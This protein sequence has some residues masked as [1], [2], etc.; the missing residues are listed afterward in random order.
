MVCMTPPEGGRPQEPRWTPRWNPSQEPLPTPAISQ[1]LS[2]HSA[3]FWESF[4][5]SPEPVM[6]P[7][8]QV[9]ELGVVLG[10]P[11]GSWCQNWDPQI[12]WLPSCPEPHLRPHL[13]A[14]LG[15]YHAFS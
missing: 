10:T 7:S 11:D 3:E 2:G 8:K 12:L 6:G 15:V 1:T 5:D 9:S 4:S 13:R 14:S